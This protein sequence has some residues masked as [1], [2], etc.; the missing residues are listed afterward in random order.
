MAEN[1]ARE[2]FGVDISDSIYIAYKNTEGSNNIT[3]AQGDIYHMPFSPETFD[4]VVCVGVLQ[5]LPDPWGAVDELLCYVKSG[6][7]LVLWVYG[8]EGNY[9]SDFLLSH[10]GNWYQESCR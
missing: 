3:V 7:T 6:G 4:V 2:V 1:G 5:H 8:R 9:L 10:S